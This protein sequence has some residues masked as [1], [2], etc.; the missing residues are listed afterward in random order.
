MMFETVIG[1]EVHV[2]LKTKTKMFTR[3]PYRYGCEPNTLTD[4]VVWALP[5][6]LPVM[7]REAIMQT[8][9]AGLIFDSEIADICKWDR[10]NYFYPDLPKGYQISQYDRPLC[11]GGTVEIELAG[12]A[13][14]I[15][16]THRKVLLNRIHLEEDV[17]KLTHFDQESLIDYNRAGTPLA[18]IVSEPDMHSVEEVF[19]YLKSLRMHLLYAGIADCDMEK[20][21]MRCDANISIRPKGE[22]KLG[23]K[24]ELK[25]LNSI[26]GVCNGVKYEIQRQTD[27][28]NSGGRVVQ[29]TRRWDAD[30]NVSL[31]MRSKED[32]HDYRYFPDPDLMPVKISQDMRNALRAEL[33]ELPFRKQ[34]RY[35]AELG[36]PFTI[37]SVICPEKDLADFF[38]ACLQRNPK[39]KEIANLVANDLLRELSQAGD[40][41]SLPIADSLVKPAH[42]AELV[43]LVDSGAISKPIAQDVFK[44]MFASG[45]MPAVIVRE[46]GLTQSSNTDEL[47]ALCQKAIADNPK[48]VEQYKAG[49]EQ[50]INALKGSVMK[51]T[52]GKANPQMIDVLLKR[53]IK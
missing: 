1:L 31:S 10:K 28:V 30:K 41:G 4:A 14:N 3:A 21:Q 38:E 34:E 6:A 48:A 40:K 22:T 43:G 16:G 46:E 47:E 35:Q 12:S 50:S 5:G 15:M 45:K 20:G 25:N 7:N 26:S 11:R 29:E 37:T 32:A 18:E 13:R 52:Q 17:G 39:P 8:V 36:L 44:K 9:K 49:K 33:P 24:V 2:Q 53:L 51:A 42:I 23:T 27:L 19:A